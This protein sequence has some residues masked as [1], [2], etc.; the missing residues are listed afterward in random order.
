MTYLLCKWKMSVFIIESNIS[1]GTVSLL[2][3]VKL[4]SCDTPFK[5][6]H[7]QILDKKTHQVECTNGFP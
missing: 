5:E 3:D 7:F 4:S 6:V 1:Q 2:Q